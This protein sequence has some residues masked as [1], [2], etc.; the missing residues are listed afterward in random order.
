MT[1]SQKVTVGALAIILLIAARF[2]S[3]S[4]ISNDS[5]R[6]HLRLLGSSIY[7]YH[8]E[9]G[10]WPARAEDLAQTSLTVRSPYWKV[11][12]DSGTNVLVWHDDLKQNPAE[13]ATVVLAYHNKGMLAWFGR[14]WVCWGDLR[15]E[16]IPSK[17]L[18]AKLKT[19]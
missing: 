17:E 8:D 18:R 19:R 6:L 2:Y 5:I 15:T 16:Y 11:M 3:L 13:N 4:D 12:L 9:T 7:E 1:R 14:Q 10:H